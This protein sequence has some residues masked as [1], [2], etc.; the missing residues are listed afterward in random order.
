MFVR[1]LLPRL[2]PQEGARQVPQ[3][4]DGV[5]TLPTA[6]ELH[7]PSW[8]RPAKREELTFT[9]FTSAM[10]LPFSTLWHHTVWIQ[11]LIPPY[12]LCGSGKV[13]NLCA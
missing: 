7:S 6:T 9:E 13:P 3:K 11:I 2:G 1:F 10:C 5:E 12:L 8:L 4:A